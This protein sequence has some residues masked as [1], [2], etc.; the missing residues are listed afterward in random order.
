MNC[1]DTLEFLT[2][3][4]VICRNIMSEDMLNK[5]RGVFC[6]NYMWERATVDPHLRDL[7]SVKESNYELGTSERRKNVLDVAIGW[8]GSELCES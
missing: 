3:E 8:N 5:W 6:E 7:I 4:L 1:E 2:R